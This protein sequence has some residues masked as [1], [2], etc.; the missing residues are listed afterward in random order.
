MGWLFCASSKD[1]LVAHIEHDGL[2]VVDEAGGAEGV[3][4][5]AAGATLH[6]GPDEHRA[7]NE[8]DD[9]QND[10]FGDEVHGAQYMPRPAAARDTRGG[11]VC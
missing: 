4:R 2:G 3:E 1:E 7:R 6:G 5:G 9:D 11:P 8:R 10:V